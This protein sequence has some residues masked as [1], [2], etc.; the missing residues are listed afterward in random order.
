MVVADQHG[1]GNCD[2]ESQRLWR[3]AAGCNVFA[4]RKQGLKAKSSLVFYGPTQQVAEKT[5]LDKEAAP[6]AARA[7][8]ITQ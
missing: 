6:S 8:L 7:E 4:T 5:R 1:N 3:I 2:Q